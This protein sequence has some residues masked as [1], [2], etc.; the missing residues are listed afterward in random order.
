MPLAVSP[1]SYFGKLQ[2]WWAGTSSPE[3][4]RDEALRLLSGHKWEGVVDQDTLLTPAEI[5]SA[6]TWFET[7]AKKQ[8][9]PAQATQE[10]EKMSSSKVLSWSLTA[11]N[12]LLTT[13]SM[14]EWVHGFAGMA[15]GVSKIVNG[16]NGTKFW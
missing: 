16:Q 8:I 5:K 11:V 3:A 4:G 12:L 1:E 15:E 13:Y 6:W 7:A 14:A 9:L 10:S 2:R